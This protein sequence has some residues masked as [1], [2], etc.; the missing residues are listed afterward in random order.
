[1]DESRHLRS[2][3][4]PYRQVTV[5]KTEPTTAWMM[6]V[7]LGGPDL[8]GMAPAEPAASIRLLLPGADGLVLP[9]WNGNEFLLPDGTRPIIRTFTPRHRQ[10]DRL[11]IDVVLHETGAASGWARRAGPG[12]PA[13]VSGPGRGSAPEAGAEAY[14]LAGDET[15]VPAIAQLLETLSPTGRIEVLIETAHPGD[16]APLPERGDAS[17]V[18]LPRPP[19]VA[20]GSILAAAVR[21]AH[22]PEGIRVWAAGE[23]AAM[24][25]IRRH[26]SEREVPR[27]H[28]T[29]RGYWKHGKATGAT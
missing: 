7:T 27:P 12:D 11:D 28:T 14:L 9:E 17:V 26:L 1:M 13:A 10:A 16:P 2:E 8:T 24:Q 20:A 18:W 3:P 15:A 22:L 29:V 19:E 5:Q 25:Q 23:A 21:D 6:R 4:P